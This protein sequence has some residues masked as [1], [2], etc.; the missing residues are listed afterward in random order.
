MLRAARV[1]VISIH[2]LREEGDRL[3]PVPRS[4][5]APISIHALREEGDPAKVCRRCMRSGISIH[6]L[7]EE[8]DRKKAKATEVEV[9][10]YPRPPRGGR[11]ADNVPGADCANISI[12]ALREE[13]DTGEI[14]RKDRPIHFY[15]RPPRG[16]R[17]AVAVCRQLLTEHF[18]PRPPRGGRHKV[19]LTSHKQ[20]QFL[21]TP[22]A[23]RATASNS[24]VVLRRYIFLSTPS[25]RRA[26]CAVYGVHTDFGISIHALREEG[27]KSHGIAAHISQ[28]FY[29]RPPRGGR[30]QYTS[31]RA[32]THRFL[33]TPSAR[34]ATLVGTD[35]CQTHNISIHALREEG[36]PSSAP[37]VSG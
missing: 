1:A 12:H 24:V 29:P 31:G 19:Q 28:N 9:D 34:R 11:H 14:R 20:H 23:R 3:V 22:S 35:D 25:A 33:S 17:L 18:Y 4:I 27:D 36:D 13:G 2:A 21:S 7:R 10:F 37:R 30:P 32:E 5:F 8:D 6:A 15:P 26:T 16:G